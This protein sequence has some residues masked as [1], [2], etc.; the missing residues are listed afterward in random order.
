[1]QVWDGLGNG[2]ITFRASDVGAPE[3]GHVVE[4]SVIQGALFRKMR[5]LQ[6]ASPALYGRP[7]GVEGLVA[8]LPY[9][10]PWRL[11]FC[12]H[13]HTHHMC[14]VPHR[15]PHCDCHTC[16]ERI[17]LPLLPRRRQG[18]RQ[19]RCG[20]RSF[21]LACRHTRP[22]EQLRPLH[23][24]ADGSADAWSWPLVHTTD[25][26][27]IRSRVVAA[28]DGAASPVR[29]MAGIGTASLDYD[30]VRAA[31]C[32]GHLHCS[33]TSFLSL[34]CVSSVAWWL[35]FAAAPST[36]PHG[37]ASCRTDRW[38]CFPC[39][40]RALPPV[41]SIDLTFPPLPPPSA[42]ASTRP[43]CG[44][45]RPRRPS[46]SRGWSQ[47]C[48]SRTADTHSGLFLRQLA[49]STRVR[50]RHLSMRS[51]QHWRRPHRQSRRTFPRC[52]APFPA[53]PPRSLRAWPRSPAPCPSPSSC[54]PL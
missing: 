26:E 9:S 23:C 54:R 44:L 18:D 31:Q 41:L 19:R 17:A 32:V 50:T 16:R 15:V 46:D 33:D 48:D 14:R 49:L 24:I 43:S 39:V 42:T 34:P 36:A 11:L 38:H 21:T 47:R 51:T 3:L 6:G 25:G 29:A 13:T 53:P 37:S 2:Y 7:A 1:M 28:C 12:I 27:V 22:D 8:L 20:L 4:H 40:E 5:E 10:W 52:S 30:Q 45:P 35:P